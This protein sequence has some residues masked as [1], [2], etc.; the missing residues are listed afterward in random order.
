MM[1]WLAVVAAASGPA[2][3]M[4]VVLAPHTSEAVPFTPDVSVVL[5]D[6][7]MGIGP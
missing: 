4:E 1:R 5:L 6:A 7:A 3:S 2:G